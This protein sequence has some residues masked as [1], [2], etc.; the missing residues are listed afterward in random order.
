MAGRHTDRVS[1]VEL[2]ATAANTPI[3][4]EGPNGLT[5][6]TQPYGGGGPHRHYLRG[7]GDGKSGQLVAICA[8]FVT[9]FQLRIVATAGVS[10]GPIA[11]TSFERPTPS[12]QCR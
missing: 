9:V 12:G 10:F 4:N 6:H 2:T 3:T 5:A 1:Q 11:I 7:N 8:S